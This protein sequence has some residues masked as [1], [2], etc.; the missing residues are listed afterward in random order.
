MK[1]VYF[2]SITIMI[3]SLF[4]FVSLSLNA[5]ELKVGAGQADITP[6]RPVLLTGQHYMR[7]SKKVTTPIT[8]QILAMEGS[9]RNKTAR[10]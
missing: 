7:V 9:Y 10:I 1:N 3:F 2:Q 5:A 4:I 8:A 6:P